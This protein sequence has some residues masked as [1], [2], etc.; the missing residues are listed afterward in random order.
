MADVIMPKMGDAMDEG[1]IVQWLKKVGDKVALD[2]PI[3]EIET[4]KSNVEVPAEEAGYLQ[5][6]TSQAGEV[7]P[8]GQVIGII[9]AT[10]PS[11]DAP[12]AAPAATAA[13]AS[14]QAMNNNGS[15]AAVTPVAP[16]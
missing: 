3:L 8:V 13:A 6:I 1:K 5:Q 11:G 14:M 4:D 15:A 9:G 2:E 12:V 10:P 7:I 16:V